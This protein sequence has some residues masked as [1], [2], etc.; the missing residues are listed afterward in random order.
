MD[1]AKLRWLE[2]ERLLRLRQ[3]PRGDLM[4][5]N[6]AP[7]AQYERAWQAYPELLDCRGTVLAPDGAVVAKA[8]R[9]FFNLGEP[10]GPDPAT[11]AGLGTPEA[12]HKLDGSMVLSFR[13]PATGAR[14]FATRG[15][16]DSDQ[17]TAAAR[18][19]SRRHE[20]APLE[21]A[22]TYVF[23]YTGPAN[24]IVVRYAEEALTLIGMVDPADG[25]EYG[26]REVATEAARA[27]LPGVP[28]ADGEGWEFLG[29]REIQ[30]FEG[31][32]L[33][34]PGA[35]VRAKVKL[36]EYRR[37]H[38]IA[39]G[40]SLLGIWEHLSEGGR[41][42]D[43]RRELPEEL[44]PWFDRAAGPLVSGHA[45]GRAEVAGHLAT[46]RAQGWDPGTR[47]GRKAAAAYIATKAP[48]G[49]RPALFLALDGRDTGPALWKLARPEGGAQENPLARREEA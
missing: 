18:F 11:L 28:W 33:F 17:A 24:R 31:Y 6:Y 7:R 22:L 45:A 4:I 49:L 14:R 2:R 10:C 15:S 5:A 36:G 38:K 20:G 42:E 43:L 46:L 12:A 48:A 13:D 30:N 3:E 1:M 44:L 25:R 47:E 34:W 21:P 27:G 32:V 26:Y 23:E 29:T 40:L 39:T 35:G 41:A 9:K 16:F 37:L 19:W 8:F